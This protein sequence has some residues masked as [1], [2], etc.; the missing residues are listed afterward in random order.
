MAGGGGVGVGWGWGGG[1]VGVGTWA[2]TISHPRCV[3]K[4][5]KAALAMASDNVASQDAR[6]KGALEMGTTLQHCKQA[7]VGPCCL[8]VFFSFARPVQIKASSVGGD[9]LFELS[10]SKPEHPPPTV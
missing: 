7:S 3:Q 1:G 5:K 2:R 8:F 9:V 6:Q 10:S 4:K